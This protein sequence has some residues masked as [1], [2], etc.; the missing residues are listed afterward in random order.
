MI[1]RDDDSTIIKYIGGMHDGE[2]IRMQGSASAITQL[3][4]GFEKVRR[5]DGSAIDIYSP[6]V[7]GDML[8]FHFD[9]TERS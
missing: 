1:L 4:L 6:R 3:G 7:N 8:E 9:H 5:R 2:T